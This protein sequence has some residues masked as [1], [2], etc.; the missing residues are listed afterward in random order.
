[1]RMWV[2][3]RRG[4]AAIR[5]APAALLAVAVALA[6]GWAALPNPAVPAGAVADAS[7]P[8]MIDPG[9]GG[10]DGG[11]R[12]QDI[13]EKDIVLDV[14]LRLRDNLAQ[15]GIPAQLTREQDQDLGGPLS[16]GRHRRDLQERLRRTRAC[17]ARLLISL[18]VNV[19]RNPAERGM[20]LLYP[21]GDARA[22]QLA[23][24]LAAGLAPLH[25]RRE[26]P[27][28]RSNLFLLR[29]CPVPAVIVEMGFIT[30]SEDRAL[31]T[32]PQ[33]R[34]KVAAALAGVLRRAYPAEAG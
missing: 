10:V 14:A 27:I 33:Y 28:P 29:N 30:N 19:S 2:V 4:T 32:A 23:E 15:A 17:S 26:P 20:L 13:L 12:W 8:V 25:A 22:R 11:A 7:L 18:H 3:G 1:M 5:R 21:R 34:A 6:A 31:L 9:H 24:A 16:P